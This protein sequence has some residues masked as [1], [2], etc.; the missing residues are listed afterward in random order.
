[1]R[2]CQC[3]DTELRNFESISSSSNE[4]IVVSSIFLR[5]NLLILILNRE[6]ISVK[7]DNL[8][9]EVLRGKFHCKMR[10][11]SGSTI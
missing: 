8:N 3:A 11:Q 5:G 10:N 4:Y 6:Q 7:L 2:K 1:M 9:S